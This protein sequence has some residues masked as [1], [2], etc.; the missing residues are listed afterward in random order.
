MA[1]INRDLCHVFTIGFAFA[2]ATEAEKGCAL[3]THTLKK[4]MD[5][6]ME[7]TNE[8]QQQQQQQ[9]WGQEQEHHQEQQQQHD[10]NPKQEYQP[11]HEYQDPDGFVRKPRRIFCPP[12]GSTVLDHATSGKIAYR[13]RT[14]KEMEKVWVFTMCLCCGKVLMHC[15]KKT[16]S[17]VP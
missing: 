14:H 6:P 5:S 4:A 16:G 1:E 13:D 11:E 7:T 17:P 2:Q 9:G 15:E 12:C 8:Q 3:S 10:H